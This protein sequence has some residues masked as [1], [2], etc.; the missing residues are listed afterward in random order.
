MNFANVLESLNPFVMK[1]K[2]SPSTKQEIKMSTTARSN[3][4]NDING[5]VEALRK[6][7]QDKEGAFRVA[8]WLMV[9]EELQKLSEQIGN[10]AEMATLTKAQIEQQHTPTVEDIKNQVK[11][12]LQ[13]D[14]ADQDAD[15]ILF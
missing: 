14:L 5:L 8:T 7:P 2:E 1:E 6:A 3:P 15:V 13:S 11:Q 12:E 4:F 10:T 9:L